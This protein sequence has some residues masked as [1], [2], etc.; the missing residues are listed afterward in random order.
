MAGHIAT[1]KSTTWRT[2]L[3]IREAVTH[4]FKDGFVDPCASD[5]ERYWFAPQNLSLAKGFNGLK[6]TWSEYA[7]AAFVN[8]P[9]GRGIADWIGK[10]VD[11]WC[12][13]HV[14]SV[15]LIPASVDTRAW[16]LDIFQFAHA[17]CFVKGRIKF[18]GEVTG[19]APMA[20][21]LVYLGSDPDRFCAFFGSFGFCFEL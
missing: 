9:Y 7:D 8:P 4:F 10:A 6:E 14:E 2:P 11:V 19:P 3:A 15:L 20:C 21:A 13:G 16:Q 17:V 18:E 1:S 5:E 12:K